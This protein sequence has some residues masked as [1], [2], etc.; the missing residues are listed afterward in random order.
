MTTDVVTLDA[1]DHLD[2][3]SDIMTL[4]RIR[5]MPVVRNGKLVGILSQRDLFRGAVSSALQFRPAAERQWLAKI[6]VAEVMTP[7]VV[8]AEPDWPV[9]H[10]VE[11]M[12]D[13]RIGCLPVVD[14]EGRVVGLLSESDCLRLLATYLA[15]GA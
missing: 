3:A 7:D 6:R 14:T 11:V 13:G 4:G 12:V 9:R 10:A 8:T 5:H 15:E 2:L 1:G